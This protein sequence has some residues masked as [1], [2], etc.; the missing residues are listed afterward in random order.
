MRIPL[1]EATVIRRT[2]D[3]V[4]NHQATEWNKLQPVMPLAVSGNTREVT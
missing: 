3:D 1:L 2:D 4:F